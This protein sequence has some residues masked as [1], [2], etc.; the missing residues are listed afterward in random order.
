M[1]GKHLA[2]TGGVSQ[3]TIEHASAMSV[4]VHPELDEM[5]QE[6]KCRK[7]RPACDTP[8]A[9]ACAIGGETRPRSRMTMAG[10]AL[11]NLFILVLL[12]SSSPGYVE[13]PAR[14]QLVTLKFTFFQ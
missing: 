2:G 14:E 10:T 8:K 6:T 1:V 4:I 13:D 3:Q 12:L 9:S 5:P 11:E 7:K